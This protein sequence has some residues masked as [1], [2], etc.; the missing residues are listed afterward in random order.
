MT[1]EKASTEPE[2]DGVPEQFRCRYC[3][4]DTRATTVQRKIRVNREWQMM[5]FCC[6][7]QGGLYQMGCEG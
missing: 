6:T 4:G 2:L 3:K 5:G 7:E 1:N